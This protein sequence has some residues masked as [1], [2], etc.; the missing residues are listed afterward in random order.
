[1]ELSQSR[2]GS[3]LSLAILI[4]STVSSPAHAQAPGAGVTCQKLGRKSGAVAFFY[5]A[6]QCPSRYAPFVGAGPRGEK[7]DKGDQGLQGIKGDPGAKGDQ[8][9]KGDKGDKGDQG[10][11]GLQGLR[12][13]KGDKGDQG[14]QGIQGIPG[15]QGPQGL[16]IKGD[17][18]DQGERGPQGLKGD[19]GDKGEPGTTL[20]T[21]RPGKLP[22]SFHLTPGTCKSQFEY[23]FNYCADSEGCTIDVKS[24]RLSDGASFIYRVALY[25]NEYNGDSN[26]NKISVGT[27][28]DTTHVLTVNSSSALLQATVVNKHGTQILHYYRG[29]CSNETIETFGNALVTVSDEQRLYSL[30]FNQ[31]AGWD[32]EVTI[33]DN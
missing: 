22:V 17:K 21:S 9:I 14:I 6:T 1:M 7:G 15:I 2:L 13:D 20:E 33:Y 16:S 11:Q 5:N 30:S 32:S 28:L 27:S 4:F 25:F 12:G 29:L 3:T 8:G 24:T 26:R 23:I 10:I 18:G 19:K 31:L